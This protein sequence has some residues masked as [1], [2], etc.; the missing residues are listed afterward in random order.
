MQ[1]RVLLQSFRRPL[2]LITGFWLSVIIAI[3]AVVRRLGNLMR[4]S[5]TAPPQMALLDRAFSSHASLTAMHIVPAAIF[6]LLSAA[7]L[8]GRAG[9]EWLERLFF[10]FGATTG[11]TAYA[12][13]FYAVG[14]WVER[15]AVLVFN[16]WFLFSLCRAYRFRLRDEGSQARK[17]MTRAT[18]ILLGIAT[19]RPVMIL[20][21]AT[22]SRTHLGPEQF[23]GLAFWIGFSVNAGATE[24]WLRSTRRAQIHPL[25][26]DC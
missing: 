26:A 10:L 16:S 15:C 13:S 14:G 2:W 11:A 19:T 12:M 5:H 21:F 24:L 7:V 8:V 23:F 17:W 25:K 3:A 6:V 4:P 9:N 18:G 22:S 1:E 20:F